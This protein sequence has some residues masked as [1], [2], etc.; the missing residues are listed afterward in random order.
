MSTSFSV[1]VYE[2]EVIIVMLMLL[3]LR[4]RGRYADELPFVTLGEKI[5]EF[6]DLRF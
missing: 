2:F 6:I 5:A 4:E 3:F 1:R